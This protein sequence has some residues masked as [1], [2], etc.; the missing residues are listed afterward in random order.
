MEPIPVTEGGV[1]PRQLGSLLYG[2]TTNNSHIH[3]QG[4]FMLTNLPVK[5]VFELWEEA[6]VHRKNPNMQTTWTE[7]RGN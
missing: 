6:T 7:T 1:H 4:Q 5:G 2:N 3:T